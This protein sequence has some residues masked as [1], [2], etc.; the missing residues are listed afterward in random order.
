MLIKSVINPESV[1]KTQIN[2]CS[3][4]FRV[5]HFDPCEE[6]TR[7]QVLDWVKRYVKDFPTFA[8][9]D[10]KTVL[11]R[12]DESH[13]RVDYVAK[14]DGKK[15]SDHLMIWEFYQ[16][17]MVLRYKSLRFCNE[18]HN[19]EK[20]CKEF[21]EVNPDFADDVNAVQKT[22]RTLRIHSFHQQ[23]QPLRSM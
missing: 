22:R 10:L 2:M 12:T 1:F 17:K 4:E 5:S 13:Y 21:K 18:I 6:V 15:Y 20:Y 3:P 9:L 8:P 7:D 14:Y 16:E 19:F 11:I 23:V